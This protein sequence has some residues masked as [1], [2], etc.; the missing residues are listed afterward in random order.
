MTE[1]EIIRIRLKPDIKNKLLAIKDV[2]GFSTISGTVRQL[3]ET[4]ISFHQEKT[5]RIA[6]IQKDIGVFTI[7]PIELYPDI[8][9]KRKYLGR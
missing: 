1:S 2:L 5:E 8:K 3:I 6:K 4:G 7:K 9:I